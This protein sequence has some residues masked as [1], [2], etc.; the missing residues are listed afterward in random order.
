MK[1]IVALYASANKGKTTT[2]NKLIDLLEAVAVLDEKIRISDDDFQAS[3]EFFGKK[4]VVCTAGDYGEAT[5][6]SISFAKKHGYDIL[7]TATRTR[8]ET[9]NGIENFANKNGAELLWRGKED[10]EEKNG[11]IA[12]EL[13]SLIVKDIASEFEDFISNE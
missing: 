10:N 11:I 3:F 4:V 1:K 6:E 2:L 7:V 5:Q 13:L 9:T 8:G 12:A